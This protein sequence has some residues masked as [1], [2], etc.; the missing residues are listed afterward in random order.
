MEAYVPEVLIKTLG[1]KQI[2]GIL[3]SDHMQAYRDAIITKKLA[4]MSFYRFGLE[5]DNFL[6][7]LETDFSA[8]LNSIFE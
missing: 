8:A 2:M 4:S 6:D 7:R 1:K 3:D 5:W